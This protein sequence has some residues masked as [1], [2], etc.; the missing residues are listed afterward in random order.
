LSHTAGHLKELRAGAR[1]D[2]SLFYLGRKTNNMGRKHRP[3]F[4]DLHVTRASFRND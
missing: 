1:H 3:G 2:Q 4:A